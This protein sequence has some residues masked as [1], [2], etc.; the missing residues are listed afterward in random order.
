MSSA[1]MSHGSTSGSWSNP[2]ATAHATACFTL[3]GLWSRLESYRCQILC[4]LSFL[5]TIALPLQFT[6][7]SHNI[8]FVVE[9]LFPQNER[10]QPVFRSAKIGSGI[11]CDTLLLGH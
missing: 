9:G 10:V 7:K 3:E 6:R 4:S 5:L 11:I 2:S 1:K 8:L